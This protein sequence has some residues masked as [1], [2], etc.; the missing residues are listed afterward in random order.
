MSLRDQLLK[1]GLVSKKRARAVDQQAKRD[2]KANQ[3]KK[4][5]K[6][7]LKAEAD[8]KTA[9]EAN[10]KHAARKSAREASDAARD[11]YESA[12]RVRNLILGNRMDNRG[13]H[14]FFHKA[15]DGVRLL[16]MSVHPR[17]AQEL[18]RGNLA[19]AFLD[20]GNRES[21][22]LVPR[23]TAA[24]LIELDASVVVHWSQ[25][26]GPPDPSEAVFKGEWEPSIGP[27]RLAEGHPYPN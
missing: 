15:K 4:K 22:V 25:G 16:K 1:K 19:I 5:R 2:R 10:E 8:A 23:A 14:P 3:G 27:H 7:E 17:V 18:S 11:R 21:Y 12:L 6:R 13:A 26:G 24:T 9:A 20:Q